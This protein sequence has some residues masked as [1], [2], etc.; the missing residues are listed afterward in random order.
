MIKFSADGEHPTKNFQILLPRILSLDD[1]L[2]PEKGSIV[3]FRIGMTAKGV[4]KMR[5]Y[6]WYYSPV[7]VL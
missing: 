5:S 2:I 4:V 6:V 3:P 7:A 1:K